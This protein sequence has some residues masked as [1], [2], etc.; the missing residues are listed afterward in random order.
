MFKDGDMKVLERLVEDRLDSYEF[1][2]G[3]KFRLIKK[4]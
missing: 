3:H 1:L 4:S 2:E